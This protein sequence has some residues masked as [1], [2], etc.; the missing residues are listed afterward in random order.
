MP[1]PSRPRRRSIPPLFALLVATISILASSAEGR[2]G[3]K[4]RLDDPRLQEITDRASS[5]AVLFDTLRTDDWTSVPLGPRYRARKTFLRLDVNRTT[6]RVEHFGFTNYRVTYTFPSIFRFDRRETTDEFDFYTFEPRDFSIPGMEV[7]LKPINEITDEIMVAS[8]REAFVDAVKQS[9]EARQKSVG[10]RGANIKINLPMPELPGFESI[11]GPAEETSISISGREEIT[12]AGESRRVDPFLGTE[13]RQ[14]Q[15]LF[16][17][18]E[19]EQKLQVTLNGTV[20]DKVSVKVD[21]DSET[22]ALDD[23]TNIELRYDGYEDEIL[24]RVE[25]GNTSLSL[26]G[27]NLINFSGQAKGLFGIKA[28]AQ[29]GKTDI[30]L[31]ASKEEGEN[32]SASFS[33]TGSSLAQ[34]ETRI[35]RDINYIKNQYFRLGRPGDGDFADIG[36]SQQLE[37][38]RSLLSSDIAADPTIAKY[39][40]RA[41]V[42]YRGNGTDLT[43]FATQI[44]QNGTASTFFD[45]R[46]ISVTGVKPDAGWEL[47][48][49]ENGDYNFIVDFSSQDIV[50]I[51]LT[52]PIEDGRAL[53]VRYTRATPEGTPEIIVGSQLSA[54]GLP[55]EQPEESDPP[56]DLLILELLKKENPSLPDQEFSWLWSYMFRNYYNLGLSN[57]DGTSLEVE[58]QDRN[59]AGDRLDTTAPEGSTVKYLQIFGLDQENQVGD[60]VPDGRIDIVE[61]RI[62]LTRGV[63][64]FPDPFAFAP[65]PARVETWTDGE[66]QFAGEYLDQYLTAQEI[67]GGP[68]GQEIDISG[69][70]EPNYFY[71]IVVRAVSTTKSFRLDAINIVENSERISIDG[72]RLA[73]GSDYTIN[74]E[75]GEIELSIE[76]AAE[77]TPDSK[78]DVDYEF[79]PLGGGGSSSLVGMNVTT[80]FSQDA[81]ASTSW[82]YESKATSTD[83]ARIGEEPTRAVVGGASAS[84]KR[85]SDALTDLVNFLP[86]V[87]TDAISTFNIAGEFAMSIPDPNTAGEAYID[88]FEGVEDSDQLPVVRRRWYP[89]SPPLSDPQGL[90]TLNPDSAAS[91][92]WYNIE[93]R[94]GTTAQDLNPNLNDRENSTVTTLDLQLRQQPNPSATQ[95]WV[96]VM[97]GFGG[98]GLDLSRGQF[99]EIW[100]NDFKPN[101]IDRGGTLHIDLGIIDEDFFEPN[102]NRKNDEDRDSDGFQASIDDTGLNGVDDEQELDVNQSTGAV[103]G[104]PDGDDYYSQRI[105]GEFS[106]INGTE[107]NLLYDTEDLDGSGALDV[108]SAYFSYAIDLAT[109]T[110]AV[111]IREQFPNYDRFNDENHKDDRWRLYRIP[112]SSGELYSQGG[113]EPN[114][115]QIRHL[116]VWIEDLPAAYSANRRFQIA[117]FKV[118]G[119]RWEEDGIRD[120]TTNEE[121]PDTVATT[122]EF[123]LGVISTKT[124]PGVYRPPINPNI[125]N[126]VEEKESSLFL[127][128]TELE[129]QQEIRIL[130]RFLGNGL[131]MVNYRDLN[132]WVRIDNQTMLNDNVEYFFRM[133]TDARNYY[134]IALPFQSEYFR[135]ANGWAQVLF[136]ISDWTNLKFETPD[137]NGVVAGAAT[138]VRDESVLYPTRLVGGPSLFNVRFLY[139]G[140]RNKNTG[141]SVSGEIWINDIYGGD[142]RRDIDYAQRLSGSLNLGGGVINLNGAWSKTGPDFRGLRQRRGSGAT[143]ESYNFGG[144]TNLDYFIPLLGFRIPI[145]G[146]YTKTLSKPKF[147]PNG[148]TEIT[149]QA[150]RDSLRTESINRRFSTQLTRKNS[151]NPLLK[152][153]FDKMTTN[154][155]YSDTRAIRPASRDTTRTMS[156]SL[157][158]RINWTGRKDFRFYRNYVLRWWLNSLDASVKANRQTVNRSRLV[159]GNFVP[160][161]NR[162]TAG[163]DGQLT[164]NYQPFKSLNSSY[165][166]N[167]R[168]DAA[169]PGDEVFGFSVGREISRNQSIKATYRPTIF[170][171]D[172]LLAPDLSVTTGYNESGGPAVRQAGDPAGVRN[173]SVNR[174]TGLKMRFES[175]QY[176][177]RFFDWIGLPPMDPEAREARR[178]RELL[179][180]PGGVRRVGTDA[181]KI[182][183]DSLEAMISPPGRRPPPTLGDQVQADTN[184]VVAD[185]SGVASDTTIAAADTTS[186]GGAPDAT[187][188]LRKLGEILSTL[189]P[190]NISVNQ[191]SNNNYTR[192]PG[193]PKLAYQLGLAKDS[194]VYALD[195]S[196]EFDQPERV[197][198]QLTLSLDS[199]VQLTDNID[200]T[201]RYSRT[202]NDSEFRESKTQSISQIWPDV[203]IRWNGLE[204]IGFFKRLF[205]QANSTFQ[206]RKTTSESGF[207]DNLDN[208]TE[209]TT[210][211]PA[212][213][214][215]WKKYEVSSNFS[216]G[217]SKD[218]S[219]QPNNESNRQNLTV[220]ADFR[221]A[222]RGGSGIKIPIPGL[223]DIKWDSTLDSTLRLRYR[224][225]SGT[226]V[227]NLVE[228]EIPE[229][230]SLQVSPEASYNFSQT[231]NGRLFVDYTRAYSAQSD[232]T[233]TTVR[234]GISAV[235][236]F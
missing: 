100:V 20:G 134:E 104:D 113:L 47:L 153:S 40:G 57:I 37:V 35:I 216:V 229:T 156:G 22:T 143:A 55:P 1:V 145:T 133:G 139:A 122:T 2:T 101:D 144:K 191:R 80:N 66:F 121:I 234:V 181:G 223:G 45:N 218:R 53:A 192:I 203:N 15:S 8:R 162:Y 127:R 160:D 19:L 221:K 108:N 169:L 185:T 31:I 174:T 23:G 200:F 65:D 126:N 180:Q 132:L 89:A 213:S 205:S 119:N 112:L 56:Q 120:I 207:R 182:D 140:V 210:I 171:L 36:G 202:V 87:D 152:Y 157:G 54:I 163:V 117:G 235:V 189:R 176:F 131:N 206:L 83:K 196:G 142:V 232:Q 208:K 50:G 86:R 29:L 102:L 67:Y 94:F 4:V 11:F 111:D 75:T 199:G 78:I 42:D 114:L 188:A 62:D 225:T 183:P 147:T 230:T 123:A 25:L 30:T 204:N 233:T 118:V 109:D 197:N 58:I 194:G 52:Q 105:Q 187:L 165:S 215:V 76:R 190:I 177:E 61:S 96:G 59:V 173:V 217:Y 209:Q 186:G 12:F 38:Y 125:E 128:Y 167:V 168:R 34:Q 9:Q 41:F 179:N 151:K 21:Y 27:G 46:D 227:T 219:E 70:P 39:E 63:L 77:L 99:L 107:G 16:P 184:R 198:D 150:N 224:R 17:S 141:Q 170:S 124:D 154:F 155:T 136:N 81:R 175:G 60:A 49:R 137:T 51:V 220:D 5:S 92:L 72:T 68:T 148:D 33:P 74:Y 64:I 130:K 7:D 13:G 97:T 178:R 158:Y 44:S 236:R 172:R 85:E 90:G 161:P 71:D 116:R 146:N 222:F 10:S 84:Y 28:L 138:D 14:S 98:G 24:K 129:P 164:A 69:N 106:K 43:D 231:I 115:L 3:F 212:F 6:T 32:S 195:G 110:T 48:R 73:R 135:G 228:T 79:K 18:L 211:G 214:L 103:T 159:N 95:D 82:L 26:P 226:R 93:P 88:D 193:R 91:F 166:I 149:S 201:G